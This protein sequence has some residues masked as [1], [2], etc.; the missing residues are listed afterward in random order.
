MFVHGAL[1]NGDLWRKV[2]PELSKDFRC[3]APDL[4]LGS[5]DR[6]MDAGR[7]P[8][9]SGAAKLIADFIAALDLQRRHARRQ[10][11]RRRALPDRHHAPPRAHR[12]ARADATATP[13]T[14]SRPASSGS[15]FW[16]RARPRLRDARCFQPMR[17]AAMRNAPI[18]LRLA[19]EERHP[20]RD[21]RRA[22]CGPALADAGVRRDLAKVLKGVHP[23]YTLEAAEQLRRVRQAGADRVGA[24]EGLL[25]GAH[26]ERLSQT[27]SRTRGSSGSRTPTRSCRRT[28]RS[29]SPS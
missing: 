23:R 9:P 3:I 16:R 10:R 4:P 29:G 5:H 13:T 1:V 22:G 6:P 14:T 11:H 26:A 20:R 24:G 19:G 25:P 12:A 18:A 27:T 17:F 2:V 7:R 15:C 8:L 28:S 21:H